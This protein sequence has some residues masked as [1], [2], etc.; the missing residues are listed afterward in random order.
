MV[1]KDEARIKVARL[2]RKFSSLSDNQMQAYNEESTKKDFVR[3]LFNALGWETENAAEVAAEENTSGGRVDYA[4][5]IAG[6][7][8]VYL[9]A[10]PL[11]ADL[12][13]VAPVRQAITYAYHKGVT[14]A[15]LSNFRALRV[16]NANL[17]TPGL[18][19]ATVLNLTADEYLEQFDRLWLLSRPAA[20]ERLLD[21]EARRNG[22]LPP[23]VPVERRLYAQLRAWRE[24]LFNEVGR[25]NPEYSAE[26][27]DEIILRFFNRLVFVRTCEDRGLEE[28]LLQGAVHRYRA[29]QLRG[30]QPLLE[31]LRRVFRRYDKY[32]DSDLFALH[33]VDQT[34]I[35][36]TTLADVLE[37]L[38]SMP[39]G[40]ADY[41]F[42]LINADILGAVYEQYLGHVAEVAKQR[43]R[44]YQQRLD[45]GLPTDTTW[46]I[47]EKPRRRKGQGI[48]YTPQ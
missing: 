6:V 2:V 23:G 37:G 45:M 13:E 3:P 27:I 36:E 28:H 1:T 41:D 24:R 15:A 9:E 10:K 46:E 30:R 34:H 7:S 42:S 20:D 19:T 17:V 11:R 8:Y 40:L 29:R 43:Q 39:A 16:F 14:W 44:E 48:Y 32:Y 21:E 38:H 31:E 4:F 33:L 35:D 18:Q 12:T 26:R 47:T 22:Q 25:Y 5:K